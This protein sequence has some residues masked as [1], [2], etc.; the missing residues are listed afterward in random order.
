MQSSIGLV[1]RAMV[2]LACLAVVPAVA[3][4]SKHGSDFAQA[5]IEAYQARTH[6]KAAADPR[7]AGGE[8]PPFSPD[9]SSGSNSDPAISQKSAGARPRGAIATGPPGR[10][11]IGVIRPRPLGPA[12]I[13]RR[14]TAISSGRAS[15]LP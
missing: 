4:Y 15:M 8:A 12:P 11:P 1:F 14:K 5:V 2:M 10:S 7:M 13:R 9:G 6:A 3:M